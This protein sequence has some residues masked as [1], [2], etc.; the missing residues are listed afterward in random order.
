ME[1][2]Q[3]SRDSKLRWTSMRLHLQSPKPHERPRVFNFCSYWNARFHGVG[4]PMTCHVHMV[5]N[6]GGVTSIAVPD[7]MARLTASQ[8][9]S[10]LSPSSPEQRGA[11]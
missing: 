2:V 6:Y 1:R 9:T 4:V 10:A 8:T 3:S 7:A 5:I 11:S